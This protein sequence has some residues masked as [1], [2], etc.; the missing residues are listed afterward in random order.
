[1]VHLISLSLAVYL[2]PEDPDEP[3]LGW[4]DD[5][6]VI[7]RYLCEIGTVLGVL[8]YVIYQQGDEIKNQGLWT[9]LKHQV[10]TNIFKYLRV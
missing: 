3:L 5:F 6:T 8:S 9:F 4:S 1:M 10:L 2:R 7:A